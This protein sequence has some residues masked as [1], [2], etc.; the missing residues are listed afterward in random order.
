V[1]LVRQFQNVIGEE[2]R[3]AASG[4]VLDSVDPSTGRVWAGVPRSSERDVAE[5][6]DAAGD[7]FDKR[8]RTLPA[9]AR[10][11]H[12]RRLAEM[13]GEHASE[14]A[15]MEARDNGRIIADTATFDLPACVE[16]L[17]YFAG[18]ADKIAGDTVEISP[19]SF[20]FT[21]RQP[22]GVVGLIVPWNA[23]LSITCAKM[24]AALAAGNTVVVKPAEQAS[25]SVLRLGELALEAGLPPGVV[26]AV[27]G[28][29]EEAGDALVR[30]PDVGRISFTGST[31]TARVIAS[32]SAPVLRPLHFELGGKSPNIVF[33]DADL[34][35][36]SIGVSTMSIFTGNA[37]QT[38]IAGSRILAHESIADE[39]VERIRAVT[40][41]IVLGPPLD[42]ATTMGPIVS[43][44]QFDRV[45]S[46][47]ELGLTE[48]AELVFGGESGAQLFP[49]G[50]DLGGGYYVAPTLFRSAHNDLR[51]CQEEI[52]G[53]VT[54]VIPFQDDD[55]ALELANATRYGLAAGV[56]T[57]DLSR[58]HRFVRALRVGSVWVNTYRKIHWAVPFGGVKDSGFGRDSGWESVLE[59][60]QLKTAWVDLP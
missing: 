48:D 43:S 52:F 10:A 44:E 34:A 36:A 59:N 23:P 17:H 25:C 42:P 20:N 21:L 24:G 7:G 15:E 50:S 6:V 49:P 39:L 1:T 2:L 19:T 13:V 12:L 41:A 31:D 54:V 60:T 35:L 51:I 33:A 53:P 8:W 46:Y 14:L 57:T 22:I 16:M 11:R 29:G 27:A 58:A 3:S 26:N 56:W 30:H 40:D 45:R 38:C 4:A 18:A 55:H 28:L 5:A 47:L 32:R 37:G 9:L